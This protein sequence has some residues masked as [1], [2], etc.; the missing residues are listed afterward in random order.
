MRKLGQERAAVDALATELR[1]RKE[2]FDEYLRS[3]NVSSSRPPPQLTSAATARLPKRPPPAATPPVSATP[4]AAAS[5]ARTLPSSTGAPDLGMTLTTWFRICDGDFFFLAGTP[6]AY[7]QQQQVHEQGYAGDYPVE[8]TTAYLLW[9]ETPDPEF[10][11]PPFPATAADK[12][13]TARSSLSARSPPPSGRRTTRA[14]LNSR[15]TAR[16]PFTAEESVPQD[17]TSRETPVEEPAVVGEGSW[18]DVSRAVSLFCKDTASDA[19]AFEA[20]AL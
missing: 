15:T 20:S 11:V 10:Y 5:T 6:A 17:N 16:Q 19:R 8:T 4:A 1:Q 12:S 7:Q 14:T 3:K 13:S 18:K 9:G 2:A